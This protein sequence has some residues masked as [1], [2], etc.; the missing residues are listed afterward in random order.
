MRVQQYVMAPDVKAPT[1]A[2]WFSGG[3]TVTNIFIW[4]YGVVL[5]GIEGNGTDHA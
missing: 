5:Q 3:M 4:C 1:S 2:I